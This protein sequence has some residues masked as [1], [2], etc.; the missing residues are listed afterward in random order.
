MKPKNKFKTISDREM[1]NPDF[2]KHFEETWPGFQLEVR[3]LNALE[4]KHWSYSDLAK[5][6]GTQKSGISRDL[7]GGGLQS[8][9]IARIAK[10]SDALGLKFFPLCISAKEAKLILPF[11]KKQAA[12]Y[13]LRP[14]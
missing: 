2:R 7:K 13:K 9:S 6:M 8:A 11:I 14:S 5:V 1:E 10:I 4:R 12:V 3:L